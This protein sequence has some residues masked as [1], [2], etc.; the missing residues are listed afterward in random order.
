MQC[1]CIAIATTQQ[2]T[3]AT[4]QSTGALFLQLYF[5]IL[6]IQTPVTCLALGIGFELPAGWQ[7][8]QNQSAA[9]TYLFSVLLICLV[10]D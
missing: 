6:V 9:E 5:L 1:T 2:Q 3:D 7:A 4:A 8:A 10:S